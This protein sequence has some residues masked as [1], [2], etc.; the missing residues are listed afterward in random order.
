MFRPHSDPLALPSLPIP[1]PRTF[2]RNRAK[3]AEVWVDV[4]RRLGGGDPEPS[5]PLLFPK[6]GSVGH[7]IREPQ[8]PPI[9][10][11]A[12]P[13]PPPPSPSPPLS[14]N[15]LIDDYDRSTES[16]GTENEGD[17]FFTPRDDLATPNVT[18]SHRRDSYFHMVIPACTSSCRGGQRSCSDIGRKLPNPEAQSAHRRRFASDDLPLSSQTPDDERWNRL[19]G[20]MEAWMGMLDSLSEKSVLRGRS[21]TPR[22]R[23]PP[24]HHP[25]GIQVRS[26]E[27]N[28]IHIDIDPVEYL[29]SHNRRKSPQT[30]Q[31]D[32]QSESVEHK[33]VMECSEETRSDQG[34]GS[35]NSSLDS[36]GPPLITII[37]GREREKIDGV[38]HTEPSLLQ[39][40]ATDRFAPPRMARTRSDTASTDRTIVPA[41]PSAPQDSSCQPPVP[42]VNPAR[43]MLEMFPPPFQ[44]AH[45][46]STSPQT[47][48]PFLREGEQLVT[49]FD[50]PDG[51]HNILFE[52]I[53]DTGKGTVTKCLVGATRTKLIEY[54]TAEADY[55]FLADFFVGYRAYMSAMQLLKLLILRLRWALQNIHSAIHTR[56]LNGTFIALHHWL[57]YHYDIDYAPSSTLRFTLSTFI[58]KYLESH[59]AI[60]ESPLYSR[61]VETLK[62]LIQEGKARN[63]VINDRADAIRGNKEKAIETKGQTELRKVSPP[64]P[65]RGSNISSATTNRSR[66]SEY[67]PASE[68]FK[69]KKRSIFRRRKHRNNILDPETDSASP[70]SPPAS[71]RSSATGS[72]RPFIMNFPPDETARHLCV[73]EQ[74]YVRG[75]QW[76][77]LLNARD[78]TKREVGKADGVWRVIDRF[79]KTCRWVTIEINRTT[80]VEEKARVIET[81]IRIAQT[82]L[83]Y[84]NFSTLLSILLALQNAAVENLTKIWSQV[85]LSAKDTLR[86]LQDF[87]TPFRNFRAIR[88]A[89]VR[90]TEGV[91]ID[92]WEGE[93]QVQL[94][95]LDVPRKS[96]GKGKG[97]PPERYG[98]VPFLGLIL[99]DLVFNE[100]IDWFLEPFGGDQPATS[101]EPGG[102]TERQLINVQRARRLARIV[103]HFRAFQHPL[104]RYE[105]DID[106]NLWNSL[107]ALDGIL[108]D[109]RA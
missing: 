105:I 66:S 58:I 11:L 108:E 101:G 51:A 7:E 60:Q 65:L 83:A 26:G 32:I 28:R 102:S 17:V 70:G 34:Y 38:M 100:E 41:S 81:F 82:S 85:S 62:A 88:S 13:L 23:S 103:K 79:N 42:P 95:G 86:S 99:S 49:L 59:T 25:D 93:D 16:S 61:T 74:E 55:E 63:L 64:L 72:Y 37:D 31:R 98:A 3:S 36:P 71:Y 43:R 89:H 53:M 56:A 20:K 75:I 57:K 47:P 8:A 94:L 52:Y 45:P 33:A 96:T 77:E 91:S 39:S 9:A 10:P 73:I 78:W 18:K 107:V 46:T 2:S 90:C 69:R 97:K 50:E 6:L 24:P 67:T 109:G 104:R 84:C 15:S 35:G 27:D 76:T 54:L 106:E 4:Q 80:D 44:D 30:G 29:I 1:P 68:T 14:I 48:S 21:P 12:S 22:K 5:P 40:M 87:A 92:A 19:I